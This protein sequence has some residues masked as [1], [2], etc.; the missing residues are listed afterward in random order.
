MSIASPH[1]RKLQFCFLLS[2]LSS[3]TSVIEIMFSKLKSAGSPQSSSL[4]DLNPIS[5]YYDIG[6]STGSAGPELAWK[7]FDATRKSDKK[8]Y[9]NRW[10]DFLKRKLLALEAST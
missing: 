6:K 8:V 5:N 3:A 4:L 7:I 10:C 2:S 1:R 9:R